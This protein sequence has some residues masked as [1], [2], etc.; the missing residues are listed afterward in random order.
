M[1]GNNELS[2]AKKT[3]RDLN[4]T[5]GNLRITMIINEWQI[6]LPV[7]ITENSLYFNSHQLFLRFQVMPE[8][9]G[10]KSG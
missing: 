6:V 7:I 1:E 5:S 10:T 2:K 4:L 8:F 3:H 9:T